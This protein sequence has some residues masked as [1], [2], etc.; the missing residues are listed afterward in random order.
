MKARRYLVSVAVPAVAIVVLPLLPILLLAAFG[1][2]LV[3]RR[4]GLPLLRFVT[5]AVLLIGLELIAIV[6]AVTLWLCFGF[7]L[8]RRTG[9]WLRAHSRVQ[10]WWM[11]RVAGV[12]RR[13][14][15]VQFVLEPTSDDV[16]PGPVIVIAR[17]ASHI[18][19]FLPGLLAG[20]WGGLHLR[21]VIADELTWIPTLNIYGNR[22]PNVFVNRRRANDA[23]LQAVA[24][25]GR[26]IDASTAAV[27]FPEGQFFTPARRERVLARIAQDAPESLERATA[28]RHVLP[29]RP[30]GLFELIDQAPAADIAVV[31]HHGLDSLQRLADLTSGFPLTKPVEVCIWRVPANEVPSD[32]TERLG[33]L[34]DQW[35][36]IDNWVEQRT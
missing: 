2:D 6:V 29:P 22:L 11:A 27:V 34:Y 35:E 7:G 8:G 1:V 30:G 5:S 19:A 18:D 12:L 23:Q 10:R 13:C 32:R 36:R 17:H 3:R 16:I 26:G 14:G 4:P 25:I 15:H 20:A 9:P 24:R 33:W 21:Y 28:L 31:A